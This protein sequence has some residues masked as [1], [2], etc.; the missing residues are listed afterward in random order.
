MV[1]IRYIYVFHLQQYLMNSDRC[2]EILNTKIIMHKRGLQVRHEWSTINEGAMVTTYQD[3][4]VKASGTVPT[5]IPA[6]CGLQ[7]DYWRWRSF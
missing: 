1:T 5:L 6:W 7:G 2:P 4:L 3:R